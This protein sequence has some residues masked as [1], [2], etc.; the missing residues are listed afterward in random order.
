MVYSLT[1]AYKLCGVK[2]RKEFIEF[3]LCCKIIK[4]VETTGFPKKTILILH[5]EFKLKEK[6]WF[7][8]FDE[9][10]VLCYDNKTRYQLKITEEGIIYLG[11]WYH[12]VVD[13]YEINKGGWYGN[14]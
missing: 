3:M 5:D 6:D 12:N 8:Y 2:T 14:D 4:R 13:E 11:D 7:K 10:D 1:E 9:S